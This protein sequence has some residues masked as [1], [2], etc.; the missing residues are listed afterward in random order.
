MSRQVPVLE[1]SQWSER[2]SEVSESASDGCL[3]LR[4]PSFVRAGHS[5]LVAFTPK[6]VLVSDRY[7][8]R[9]FRDPTYEFQT[10]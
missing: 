2:G 4:V 10:Q 3:R 9:H 5:Q 7:C 1:K 6:N 8:I